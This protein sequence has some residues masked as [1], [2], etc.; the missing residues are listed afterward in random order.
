MVDRF[1]A[2]IN[3][4]HIVGTVK[5]KE[6]AHR[7][8]KKAISEVGVPVCYCWCVLTTLTPQGKG[9]YLMDQD[10]DSPDVF[11]VSVGNLPPNADVLIRITY[12]T[13]LPMDSQDKVVFV[14]PGTNTSGS[15]SQLYRAHSPTHTH[16]QPR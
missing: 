3:G 6:E 1:E 12:V 7:E 10:E 2:F 16:P 15:A 5:E 13:E 9:G 11:T 4:K 14:L 8:Y